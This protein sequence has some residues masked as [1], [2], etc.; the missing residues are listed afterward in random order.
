MARISLCCVSCGSRNKDGN[1]ESI[2]Q[3]RLVARLPTA[4]NKSKPPATSST[5]VTNSQKPPISTP[6]SRPVP[7]ASQPTQARSRQQ[8][9]QTS[10]KSKPQEPYSNNFD[11]WNEAL[12]QLGDSGKD[13]Y[14]KKLLGEPDRDSSDV[15]GLAAAIQ[16]EIRKIFEAQNHDNQAHHVVENAVAILNKFISAVDVAVSF[17]PVHAALPWA[18][19]R[20]VLVALTS[21]S[22]L[23]S[24]VVT[25]IATVASLLAQCDTYQQL[26]IAPDLSLRPPKDSLDKL[27]TSIVETYAKSQAFLGFAI[28]LQK[29]KSTPVAAPFKIGDAVGHINN[30]S[31]CERQLLRAADDCERHCN[32]LNRS[33]VDSLLKLKDSFR[34]IIQDQIKMVLDQMNDEDQ[35]KMLEWISPIP[36]GRHHNRVKEARTSDTCEW[37]LENDRFRQWEDASSSTILWLQGSP[38]AGKTFLTSKVIDHGRALIENSPD[39]EGFAFFYC[40][41]NEEQRRK[42][43]SILQSYV[44][45]L[46]TTLKNPECIR[47]QLQDFCR[48]ART[49]GS[50]LGVDNCKEQL[51]ESVN[52][53]SRTTIVLDALDE[54]EINSR[55]QILET[56]EYLVS[57]SR[58]VLKVFI[59]SRPDRDI[60]DRFLK[61]PSIEIQAT[62]NQEDIKKFVRKE[63]TKH[64]NWGG[65]SQELQDDIVKLL[66]DKSQGMF[67]WAFLQIKEILD[68]ETEPAIRDRLGKLPPDLKSAYDEIYNKIKARNNHDRTLAKNAFKWVACAKKPMNSKE[69]LSAIRLDSETVAFN[70][71]S[72][73]TESQLLHLCN[74]LLVIDS[75]RHIWRFSH[76]S[77]TEYFEENY[78]SL[79]RAHSH[80]ASVC[81]KLLIET[82]KDADLDALSTIFSPNNSY[83]L[84]NHPDDILESG[85]AFQI[86]ARDNWMGH[87][88]GQ[89][90]QQ[91]DPVLAQL[92]K[93]F[94]D[95][96]LKSS[97]QYRAWYKLYNKYRKDCLEPVSIALFAM[98]HFSF[99][100]TLLDWW[101]G[102]EFDIT[103]TNTQGSNL[104]AIAAGR[105]CKHI[106]ENLLKRGIDV[107]A[108]LEDRYGSALAAA[109]A[110][111]E[112]IEVVKFLVEA[113]VDMNMQ[114]QAGQYGSALAAAASAEGIEVVK[115]LVE[116]GADMNMQIQAGWYGSALA[117]AASNGRI[118]VVK[119]LVEAGA[120]VNMQIQ[121]GQYGSALAAAA[122][123]GRIGVLKFLVEAG[124]DVNMQIQAG[125][126]GSALAAAAS[127]DRIKVVKFL[128]EAG[129]DVNMQIQA[130][131]HGSALA[132]A[133][134]FGADIEIVKFLVNDAG[135]DVDLQLQAGYH[136]GALAAA[137]YAGEIKIVKFLVNEAG[138]DVDL[139]L[140]TGSFGSALAMAAY[141]GNIECV[142]MLIEAGA[143]VN[144]RT[145][146][147]QFRTALQASQA[148]ASKEFPR[149]YDSGDRREVFERT[150]T[151]IAEILR[152]HGAIDEE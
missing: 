113:G 122:S 1:G 92:L 118:E 43:L 25:G 59:S 146:N 71:S 55:L 141:H 73:V 85:H 76:L 37:L 88:Q 119:F 67:Q 111:D 134:A 144:L 142:K 7:D 34:E 28:Q 91:V 102:A 24:Q 33:N 26:Y 8:D 131:R 74:N 44:R 104:L 124:A 13:E 32:L 41:R 62:D 149:V 27:K 66:F 75:Q 10:N 93:S 35:I 29:S 23:Q 109:A 136:G 38:G 30:L 151:E 78:W 20:V 42:P 116:A 152:H 108:K 135:A 86:Y 69:L 17:D 61:I 58:N 77:V 65:M 101:E 96:P 56:I 57:R 60:R 64:G 49:N 46:S 83:N 90:E 123:D 127:D 36:Y 53:Y 3:P 12:R 52:L 87:V 112:G 51:L 89:E 72:E 14:T 121:A 2:D 81:L 128:V 110:N 147:G 100:H 63:I 105:G 140:Q 117:A 97:H 95:S 31:K 107:N 48:S 6:A 21:I 132:A 45:Q 9:R 115:F 40:D 120:D 106:C 47:K 145:E 15:K 94:L 5:N 80:S 125:W 4:A 70:L 79:S 114:I 50:D 139:Q 16:G 84:T 39:Q 126:Y 18:A 103:L 130:G 150:R 11:L 19:V 54:C 82:F 99:Y 137:A 22:E 148:D 138:A 133:A 68:L 129:A 143:K 98:C